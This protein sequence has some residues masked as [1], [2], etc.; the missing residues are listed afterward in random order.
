MDDLVALPDVSDLSFRA[1]SLVCRKCRTTTMNAYG[2]LDRSGRRIK[3]FVHIE[4]GHKTAYNG[5]VCDKCLPGV[6]H[7]RERGEHCAQC[8][9]SLWSNGLLRVS[10][11]AVKNGETL[12]FCSYVCDKAYDVFDLLWSERARQW[13]QANPSPVHRAAFTTN[14]TAD[15]IIL[16]GLVTALGKDERSRLLLQIEEAAAQSHWIVSRDGE[17][18]HWSR[19][20][21]IS[22]IPINN[23]L[24]APLP[25]PISLYTNLVYLE[26]H[27]AAGL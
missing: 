9:S 10:H 11:T 12:R 14:E 5:I 27:K 13:Q 15:D 7:L 2:V 20:I 16:H 22:A 26:K 3:R 24:K 25:L 17:T 8:R 4:G 18:Y 23:G 6:P 19:F 21:P 1:V